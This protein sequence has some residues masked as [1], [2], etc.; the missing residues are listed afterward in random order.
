MI[1]PIIGFNHRF[2][3][4]KDLAT[5]LFP[6]CHLIDGSQGMFQHRGRVDDEVLSVWL[7]GE[8]VK[9]L[10]KNRTDILG[11]ALWPLSNEDFPNNSQIRTG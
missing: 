6:L 7:P 9:F 11:F 2:W 10:S 4:T 8:V 3:N 5:F 1:K